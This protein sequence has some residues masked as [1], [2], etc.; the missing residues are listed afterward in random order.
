MRDA[1]FDDW[2]DAVAEG[3]GYYFVC[4]NGHGSLPPRR[5][6]PV[7]GAMELTRERLPPTGEVETFTVVHVGTPDFADETPYVTA[8]AAFGPVRL[9]GVMTD[10]AL[11][12]VDIGAEVAADVGV[13]EATGQQRVEFRPR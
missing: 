9:T 13:T 8:I 6:C 10:V 1:G 3:E 11:A 4:P 12:D 5:T 7:C 2:L